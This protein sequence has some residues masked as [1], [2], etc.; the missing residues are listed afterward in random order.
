MKKTTA[1]IMLKKLL[2][3]G[4]ALLFLSGC[5]YEPPTAV[6]PAADIS[7]E[8]IYLQAAELGE[9]GWNFSAYL[10]YNAIRGYEDS[11]E[12]AEHHLRQYA[13][14]AMDRGYYDEIYY[15]VR[16]H[17]DTNDEANREY[18]IACA[19]QMLAEGSEDST[20][21]AEIILDEIGESNRIDEMEE[22]QLQAE[23]EAKLQEGIALY[24]AGDYNMAYAAL[25]DRYSYDDPV[26]ELYHDL[27]HYSS[28]FSD[29]DSCTPATITWRTGEEP[30]AFMDR[31]LV[32]ADTPD[33]VG[34]EDAADFLSHTVMDM[35]R[36][37][38]SSWKCGD[39]YIRPDFDPDLGYGEPFV[40]HNLPKDY[41]PEIVK[42]YIDH[43]NGCIIFCNSNGFE[44]FRLLGFSSDAK[45]PDEMYILDFNGSELTFTPA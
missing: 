1:G 39:Y 18:I 29:P 36:F 15:V 35:V 32:Y 40:E 31:L 20:C 22:Q 21:Y 24:R 30:E 45:H 42:M 12:K 33:F 41:F 14:W 11:A 17:M 8:T 27:C 13:Q 28:T 6:S 23:Y 34:R 44:V 9:A 7:V 26:L 37:F 43:P 19:D 38:G 3:L 2:C 4:A 5:S 25:P 16:Y 10:K